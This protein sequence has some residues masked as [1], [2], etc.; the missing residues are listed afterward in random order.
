MQ[1]SQNHRLAKICRSP[2]F[3]RTL[4]ETRLSSEDVGGLVLRI[5]D[6]DL[7]VAA[8]GT[9]FQAADDVE[10][11]TAKKDFKGGL[12]DDLDLKEDLDRTEL[13]RIVFDN[14]ESHSS[15]SIGGLHRHSTVRDK[16]DLK[17]LP[18]VLSHDDNLSSSIKDT[19]GLNSRGEGRVDDPKR[20]AGSR[21][22]GTRVVLD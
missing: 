2:R 4:F 5:L 9:D 14:S 16:R 19:L 11:R 18:D 10:E 13:N 6:S 7:V 22:R 20:E 15:S 21:R 12:L 17:T 1:S 8:E 3:Q